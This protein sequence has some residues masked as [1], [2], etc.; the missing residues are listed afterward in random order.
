MQ[1]LH[2]QPPFVKLDSVHLQASRLIKGKHVVSY[3]PI[4]YY[5]LLG[6]LPPRLIAQFQPEKIYLVEIN[7]PIQAGPHRDHGIQCSINFYV[8]SSAARTQFWHEAPGA[9]ALVYQHEEKAHMYR[10]AELLPWCNFTAADGDA[11]LLNNSEIHSVEPGET[12]IDR[13]FVQFAWS[14]T[15]FTQLLNKLK[16]TSCS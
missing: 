14:N 9:T 15:I 7:G 16:K 5:K 6:G 4:A 8:K 1:M 11:Y 2:T 10:K 12:P 3:G 13:L